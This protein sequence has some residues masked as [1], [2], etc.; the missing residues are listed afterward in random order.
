MK[1]CHYALLTPLRV[2]SLDFLVQFGYLTHCKFKL[3]GIVKMIDKPTTK[4]H[5]ENSLVPIVAKVAL[6]DRRDAY[7][8]CHWRSLADA[9]SLNPK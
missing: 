3:L 8:L 2:H 6:L 1:I 7:L 4:E 5:C 9:V